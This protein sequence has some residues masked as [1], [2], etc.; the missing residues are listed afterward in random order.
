MKKILCVFL[1]CTIAIIGYAQNT[2][3]FLGIPIDGTKTE[4]ISKLEAKGYEYNSYADVLT[5]EFNGRDVIIS[6]QTVNNKVWR[7]AVGE[8]DKVDE[9]N[10]KIR[11]NNLY[12]QFVKNAKYVLVYGRKLTDSD[13]ISYEMIVHNKRYDTSF[14]CVD[15]AI[16]GSVWYTILRYGNDYSIALFYENN[17]NAANGDDL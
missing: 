1:L 14:R 8:K 5:G 7:I 12:D 16:N 10:A 17:D 6:V 9:A 15:I 13:D 11:Y 4:M 2:I 3:K